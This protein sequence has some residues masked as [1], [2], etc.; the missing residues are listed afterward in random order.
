MPAP[1]LCARLTRAHL[2]LARSWVQGMELRT[3]ADRYL[4]SIEGEDAADLRV[5]RAR[6]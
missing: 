2:A 4:A 3:L 5:A 1:I 6:L